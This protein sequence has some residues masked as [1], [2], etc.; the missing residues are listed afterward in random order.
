MSIWAW[1]KKHVDLRFV[2]TPFGLTRTVY[3]L[4][5]IIGYC[6]VYVFGIRVARIQETKPW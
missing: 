4:N 3:G 5:G 1:A 6:D 2:L